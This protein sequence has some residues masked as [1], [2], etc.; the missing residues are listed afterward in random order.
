MAAVRTG[1]LDIAVGQEAGVVD[2]IDHPVDP[3][4]D[5]AVLLQDVGEML[6]QAVVGRVGRAAEP[7][8]AQAERLARRL[9]DLVLF[10]AIAP[11]VLTGGSG[12][13]FGRRP[14]FVGGA[15]V[16]HLMALGPLEPR[17]DVRRQHRARQIPRC[18]MPL[19]YG[20]A[21]VMRMRDMEAGIRDEGLG[22][23]DQG[24]DTV[25]GEYDGI[26]QPCLS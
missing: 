5:Q 8:I 10:V 18:L 6:G 3:L 22:M 13:Q 19:M 24:S 25:S 11:H 12:G 9:L 21:E 20:S 4:L 15:D 7:V 16:E 26:S 23:R 14:V 2:R 17:I 1:A